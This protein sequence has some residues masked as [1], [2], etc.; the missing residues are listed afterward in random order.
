M[1]QAKKTV[2]TGW[3]IPFFCVIHVL[4]F[5]IKNNNNN[6]KYKNK[7]KERK[8]CDPAN[9]SIFFLLSLSCIT[10]KGKMN[11]KTY[12]MACILERVDYFSP[13]FD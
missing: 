1:W 13:Y 10:K 3:N 8:T 12:R 11:L 9:V 5:W 6:K 4:A 7:K 2:G